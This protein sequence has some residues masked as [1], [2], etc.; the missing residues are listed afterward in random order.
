MKLKFIDDVKGAWKLLSVQLSAFWAVIVG[1]AVADPML[2]VSAWNAIPPELRE[3]LP[4]W[5]RWIVA[6]SAMFGT[7]YL[8]RVVKQPVTKA[9]QINEE[10]K[11]LIEAAPN[12]PEDIAKAIAKDVVEEKAQGC[13]APPPGWVCSREKGHEG[14]CAAYP[15]VNAGTHQ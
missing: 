9:G 1:V 10:K 11:A 6:A 4:S 15:V 7:I 2:F 12:M 14:P 13:D 3:F 8:A 5:V